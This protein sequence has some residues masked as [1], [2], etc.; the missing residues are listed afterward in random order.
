[1][2]KAATAHHT[3]DAIRNTRHEALFEVSHPAGPVVGDDAA[4]GRPGVG[5]VERAAPLERPQLL[6]PHL[7]ER[8]VHEQHVDAA[9]AAIR[10]GT[11]HPAAE[12]P[13]ELAVLLRGRVER[14]GPEQHEPAV[15][16]H[17]DRAGI[18]LPGPSPLV[19]CIVVAV[20]Q[21]AVVDPPVD[22]VAAD[23]VQAV[24]EE[25]EIGG[26]GFADA[27]RG[28]GQGAALGDGTPGLGAE[29]TLCLGRLALPSI[30]LLA[31]C[32]KSQGSGGRAPSLNKLTVLPDRS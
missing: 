17:R 3:H 18:L 25:R 20:D 9:V 32:E 24:L 13:E 28:P 19:A 10:A 1:M 21:V 15:H 8:L 2:G 31:Q 30:R 16:Q 27:P 26:V 22:P 29:A 11:P 4:G 12:G 5:G 14:L 6:Q 7:V 23:L